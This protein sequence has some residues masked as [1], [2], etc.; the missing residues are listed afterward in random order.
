MLR[1]SLDDNLFPFS[2]QGLDLYLSSLHNVVP[3]VLVYGGITHLFV[4]LLY[5]HLLSTY[6]GLGD[7]AMN[8]TWSLCSAFTVEREKHEKMWVF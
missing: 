1:A 4:H 8:N 3:V 5:Q 6:Y 2:L 7:G